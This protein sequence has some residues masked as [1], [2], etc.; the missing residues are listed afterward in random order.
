M[1]IITKKCSVEHIVLRDYIE[2]RKCRTNCSVDPR[3]Y[4]VDIDE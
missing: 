3:R 2:K 1:S 4:E